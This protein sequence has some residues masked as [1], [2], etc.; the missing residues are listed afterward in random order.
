MGNHIKKIQIHK[1]ITISNNSRENNQILHL[2]TIISIEINLKKL[3]NFAISPLSFYVIYSYGKL[4]RHPHYSV[5]TPNLHCLKI[6]FPWAYFQLT[7]SWE[8][9]WKLSVKIELNETQKG[10]VRSLRSLRIFCYFYATDE[11]FPWLTV[12]MAVNL[13]F[14]NSNLK[15]QVWLSHW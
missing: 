15:W 1:S 7:Q 11:P 10:S 2:A 12:L 13:F 6:P 14:E 4:R 9:Q 8:T 3:P 5:I